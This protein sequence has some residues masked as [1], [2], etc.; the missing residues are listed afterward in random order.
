MYEWTSGA[1]ERL[2]AAIG[3]DAAAYGLSDREIETLLDL[4]R[5]AAHESGVK[6]NAPLIC[7]LVGL[8]HGRN[9]DRELGDLTRAAIEG[10]TPPA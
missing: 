7:Y 8:A 4:A 10:V 3:A 9:P 6:S 1:A 5:V 2:A